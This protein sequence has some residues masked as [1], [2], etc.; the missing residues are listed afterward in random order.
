M[1]SSYLK[2]DRSF[3]VYLF[4]SI[5]TFG[6]YTIFFWHF[7]A[8]DLNAACRGDDREGPD[9]IRVFLLSVITLGLYNMIWRMRQADRM[10]ACGDR[11]GIAIREHGNFLAVWLVLGYFTW[12][13]GWLIADYFLITN[14]NRLA[15]SINLH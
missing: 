11:Y 7:W 5:I 1:Q 8:L 9:Y 15:D 12:G 6:I 3:W 10:C 13:I 14:L 4:L 2:N